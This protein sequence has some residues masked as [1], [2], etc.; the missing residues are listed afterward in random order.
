[1]WKLLCVVWGYHFYKDVW[2]P[3]LEDVFTT[4]HE[5]LNHHDKYAIA[6]LPADTKDTMV[7]DHLPKEISKDCCLFILHGGP[8][9]AL[10]KAEDGKPWNLW[11][12]ENTM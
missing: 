5:R 3:Y 4:K 7:V 9:Q 1:M 12:D 2:D 8:L 10:L 11:W 6:V